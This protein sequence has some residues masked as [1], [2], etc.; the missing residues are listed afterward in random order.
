MTKRDVV[1]LVLEGKKPPYVP[2]SMGFTA[3]AKAKL[4]THYGCED[5]EDP[6]NNHLLKLGNDIGFF[7]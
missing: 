3:E 1:R 5:I 6:L 2:W 4:Q 7:T